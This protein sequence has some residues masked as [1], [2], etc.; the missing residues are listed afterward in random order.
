MPVKCAVTYGWDLRTTFTVTGTGSAVPVNHRNLYGRNRNGTVGIPSLG[1][2]PDLPAFCSSP[3]KPYRSHGA[4]Y[5]I[6]REFEGGVGAGAP[7]WYVAIAAVH[8]MTGN[9]TKK[10]QRFV[11][12]VSESRCAVR[13]SPLKPHCSLVALYQG[14]CEWEGGASARALSRIELTAPPW[15]HY[16]P[17]WLLRTGDGETTASHAASVG[18][19]ALAFAMKEMEPMAVDDVGSFV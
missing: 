7:G 11:Y 5:E 13:S 4:L 2:S 14:G 19:C 15:M 9:R 18:S 8:E 16:S 12:L 17:L 10:K 3:R 1:K 6:G